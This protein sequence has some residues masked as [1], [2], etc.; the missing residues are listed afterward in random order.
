[1]IRRNYHKAFHRNFV[2]FSRLF[3]REG[4]ALLIFPRDLLTING[5]NKRGVGV[6]A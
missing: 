3:A 2:H 6:T 5:S 4:T 1:M